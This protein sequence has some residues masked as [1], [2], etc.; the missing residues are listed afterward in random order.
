MTDDL[1]LSAL[2]TDPGIRVVVC[3]GA[4]GVGKTTTA[5][6]LALHAAEAGRHAVVLTIDPARRLAQSMGVAELDNEPTRVPGVDSTAGGSLDAMMLDMKRTFDETVLAH[7][8][9]ERRLTK[10][11]TAFLVVATPEPDALREAAYFAQRLGAEEMPLAGLVI[12][13]VHRPRLAT[14]DRQ[15]ADAAAAAVGPAAPLAGGVLRVHA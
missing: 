10:P 7:A 5:A 12:N 14:L 13:R 4:G 15:R 6:A 1:D 11:G 2:V 9:P 8:T 3:C